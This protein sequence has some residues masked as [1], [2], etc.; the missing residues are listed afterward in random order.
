MTILWILAALTAG[1][2]LTEMIAVS[3]AP[4]GYQDRQGFHFGSDHPTPTA[5][6]VKNRH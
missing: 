3:R 5:F 1:A 6:E 4:F 2:F